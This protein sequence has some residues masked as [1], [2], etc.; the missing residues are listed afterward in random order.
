MDGEGF[1]LYP[2]C[3]RSHYYLAVAF[4]QASDLTRSP[5]GSPETLLLNRYVFVGLG[6]FE[7]VFSFGRSTVHVGLYRFM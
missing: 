5:P 4:E 6:Y 7:V 2:A 3:V 1:Q